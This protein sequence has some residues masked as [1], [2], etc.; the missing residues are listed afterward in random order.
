MKVIL[1]IC[2]EHACPVVCLLFEENILEPHLNLDYY[3]VLSSWFCA[4]HVKI[5]S[6][7]S[8]CSIF[9]V[10]MFVQVLH[11]LKMVQSKIGPDDAI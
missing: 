2:M 6:Y 9:V 8:S 7:Q 11:W 1:T 4:N 5:L 10:Y 3:S